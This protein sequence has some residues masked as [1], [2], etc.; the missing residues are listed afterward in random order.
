MYQSDSTRIRAIIAVIMVQILFGINYIASKIILKDFPPPIWAAAR[1]IVAAIALWAIAIVWKRKKPQ[2]TIPFLA[3]L[4]L[5]ALLGVVINQASFLAGLRYTTATNSAVL[6]TLIPVFT[7]F[8]VTLTHQEELRPKRAVGFLLSLL[9]VLALRK[10]E[11]FSLSNQTVVGDLLTI[12]N[13]VSYALY[14]T[15][16]RKFIVDY[17]T[18][19]ITAWLFSLGSIGLTILSIPSWHSFMMPTLHAGLIGCIVFS[20]LGSTLLAYLLN[21][22]ALAKLKSSSVALFIYLQPVVAS[23][24]AWIWFGEVLTP[25]TILSSLLIFF[26]MLLTLQKK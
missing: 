10:I 6:N 8:F 3:H 16:S 23:F 24:L 18:I 4:T 19:W 11:D 14:L 5:F 1:V 15:I 25:R 21:N 9:G 20:I 22:W 2:L 12:L 26:G 7:L 17:D 13:C